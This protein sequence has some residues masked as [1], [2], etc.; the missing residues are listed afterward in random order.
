MR[1]NVTVI[2]PKKTFSLR[3]IKEL[4][5]Y[6]GL[7]YFLSWRDIKVRYKQT[8]IGGLWAI[9]QPFVTMVIFTIF[10][11]KLAGIPSDGVPYPIFVYVGLLFWQ[12]FSSALS[13]TSMALIANQ[14]IVTKV[15][16]PRLI[17]PVSA[18]ITKFVDFILAS[19]ILVGMM[20]YY[21]YVPSLTGILILPVLLL[22]T[23]FVAVGAG[24]FLSAVNVKYRDVRYA[25]PFFIQLL[26]F[27]TPVIYPASI[28]GKYSWILALNPMM[29]VVQTARAGLLHTT[30]INWALLL[31]SSTVCIVIMIIGI[32]Y[33]KKV[34]SYFADII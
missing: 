18:V 25:L 10:F 13:D 7:L 23:F 6:R 1:T 22:I 5:D 14:S 28:A 3:D 27:V 32:A 8:A 33:F 4:W 34:E 29:G 17:L 24:L 16:F 2:R 15:Y 30:P 11:G 9:L 21:H 26:L 19:I 31:L 12:F 20:F